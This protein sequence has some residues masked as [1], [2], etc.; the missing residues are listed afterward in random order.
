MSEG[1]RRY[2][3]ASE[4]FLVAEKR[5]GLFRHAVG[6]GE[7]DSMGHVNN[8]TYARWA[9]SARINWALN[10]ARHVD[11]NN[12]GK[13]E[14]L[15]T[16][17]GLGLILRSIKVDYKFPMEYPDRVTVYHKLGSLGEDS[18][19]LD[20][21]I[22]SEKH[23]RVA[24]RCVEDIVIYNYRPGDG[25]KPG[26]ARIPGFMGDVFGETLRLQKEAAEDAGEEM[27]E[28]EERV[29]R[30]EKQVMARKEMK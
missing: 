28:I 17:T 21:V 9:E 16:S 27:E 18:F 13:W 2:V 11:P 29:D 20:G 30:L 19:K 12:K 10:I 25:Q 1:W 22:L 14:S 23:Q 5:R 24:A 3:A 26:K 4:G 8:V 15:W 7:M 6:W